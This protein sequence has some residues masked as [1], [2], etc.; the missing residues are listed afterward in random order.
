[1]QT[2]VQVPSPKLHSAIKNVCFFGSADI[3]EHD[4]LYQEAF[5]V[6]RYLAYHDKVIV[7][8]GGPGVMQAST[9]GA[10]SA[11]GQTLAIT[12]APDPLEAPQFEGRFE[13]NKVDIEIKTKNYVE[14]MFGLMEHSDA[15]IVFKG[16]TGTLSEWATAWLM[17][18]I[19]FGNH[20][21]FILYGEFWNDVIQVI[22]DNFFIGQT[23]MQV[24]EV[25]KNEEEL[26]PVLTRFERELAMRMNKGKMNG[27]QKKDTA[28]V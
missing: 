6:A 23:E 17:A 20:K 11:G 9:Q 16:G 18:H 28:H 1:M 24:F 4:P 14:R 12:F 3:D 2:R 13:M 10:K 26:I 15:F 8:G 7:N 21:P 19:Y 27:E 25:V 22:T 5:N